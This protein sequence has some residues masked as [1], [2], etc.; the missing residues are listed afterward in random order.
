M[1]TDLENVVKSINPIPAIQSQLA[2]FGKSE[3]VAGDADFLRSNSMVAKLVFLVLVLV[4]F[5]YAMKYGTYLIAY[6]SSPK[7]SAYLVKGLIT[8]TTALRV[9]Q[10]PSD[11]NAV[12]IWRSNNQKTGIEFTYSVW[13]HLSPNSMNVAS[14][15]P[16]FVKGGATGFVADATLRV[17]GVSSLG[18]AAVDN[19]PGVYVV[20]NNT[21]RIAM[22]TYDTTRPAQVIDVPNFPLNKWCHMAVRMENTFMDVYVNGVISKREVLVAIPKQNFADVQVCPNGGFSGSLSNLHYVA[23]AM[24]AAELQNIVS[25]GPDTTPS[26][27]AGGSLKANP[28]PAS[29]LSDLWYK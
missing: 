17:D 3:V 25:A 8:G 7:Q 24:G 12:T 18:M 15:Q 20:N 22:D 21:V 23:R 1:S 16:I 14:A 2:S 10:D 9:R 28:G 19:A 5:M 6:S 4:I 26:L 27:A 11:A 13:L 29:Y